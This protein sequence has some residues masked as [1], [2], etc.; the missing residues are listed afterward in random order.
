MAW[1]R[2]LALD[3]TSA[4]AQVAL[5]DHAFDRAD[6]ITARRLY[7]QAR[8]DEVHGRYATYKLAWVLYD[9]G[10]RDEAIALLGTITGSD[11]L[12]LRQRIR[13]RSEPR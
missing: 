11:H 10:E 7:T 6:L 4:R 1:G 3:P 12:T 9:L 13:A 5:A 8:G 2:V